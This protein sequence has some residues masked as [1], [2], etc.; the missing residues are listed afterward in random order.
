VACPVSVQERL[1]GWRYRG[2]SFGGRP[3]ADSGVP[4]TGGCRAHNNW[5]GCVLSSHTPTTSG[6]V[7]QCPGWCR[8]GGDGRTGPTVMEVTGPAG[9]T[10]RRSPGQAWNRWPPPFE[11]S[12]VPFRGCGVSAVREWVAQCRGTDT[13][14]VA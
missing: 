2:R 1:G 12:T 3:R 13:G 6:M 7:V 10:S 5:R 9:L 14:H 11:G 8:Y 4:L